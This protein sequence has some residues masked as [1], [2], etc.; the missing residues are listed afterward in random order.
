MAWRFR[1]SFSPIPGV[2][3]TLSPSG[4]STSVGVGPLRLTAGSRGAAFTAHVPGTGLSFRQPLTGGGAGAGA[5][6]RLPSRV[7]FDDGR[8]SP[9]PAQGMQ[10]IKSA[11]S[12]VLTSAGLSAF[13][14]ALEQAQRQYDSTESEL[15]SARLQET[16]A[17]TAFEKWNN[18]FLFKHLFKAKFA[19]LRAAAEEATA[20]TVEL[21]EQL[22]LSRLATQ[23]DLPADVDAAYARL[24]DDF[25]RMARA[26]GIWD[27]VAHRAANQAQERTSATRI[28]DLRPVSFDMQQCGV[29]ATDKPV[30]HMQNANGGDFYLL[31]TFVVYMASPSNYALI[32]YPELEMN[33]ELSRY[34]EERSVPSDAEQVGKTWAKTNKDGSPDKRFRDNY[35]IPVMLY[36]RL[37][38]RTK[39]GLNEE[40]SVSNAGAAQ[41]FGTAWAELH[42]AIILS[43]AEAEDGT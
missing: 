36:A 2:R 8:G 41:A 10:E 34:L 28:V 11:G 25:A 1:K 9:V 27:N 18:G 40:Y 42:Q 33:V 16:L 15:R 31:P 23:F 13:K 32:E 7:D 35:E 43:G 20:L 26:Q 14:Q 21:Q 39:S 4:I 17:K 38:L 3:L 24:C 22:K 37:T 30:P 19:S 5:T 12:S 29:I 6:P